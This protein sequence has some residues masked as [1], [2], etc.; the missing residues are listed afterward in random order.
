MPGPRLLFTF[1][2]CIWGGLLW[3]DTDSSL[4]RLQKRFDSHH[5]DPYAQIQDELDLSIA[6]NRLGDPK[7]SMS[8]LFTAL[9]IADSIQDKKEIALCQYKI[10]VL[11]DRQEDNENSLAWGKKGLETA[12]QANDSALVASCLHRIGL[13]Y[14]GQNKYDDALEVL[15]TSLDIRKKLGLKSGVAACMNAM[16]LIYTNKKEYDKAAFNITNAYTLWKEV[17]DEEGIAIATDNLAS[18]FLSAQEPEKAVHYGLISFQQAQKIHSFVFMKEAALTLSS[19]YEQLKDHKKAL[20]Y[21][22]RYSGIKDSLI[23]EESSQK[24]AYIQ[25][26]F[27]SDKQQA[28]IESL[29]K[30]KRQEG[31][32][33]NTLII[34]AI[35][36]AL[37]ALLALNRYRLKQKANQKL[38]EANE[39][40]RLSRDE[41]Q[42]Q[43]QEI[44]DSIRYAKRLQEALLPSYRHM[45][46]FL[47]GCF[48]LYKPKDIV[49][50]DF[51]WVEQWGGKTLIAAVD[52]T[53]HG[54]PGA[55]MSVLGYS[56][57]NRAVNELGLYKPALILNEMN[58][59]VSRLLRQNKEE[60][61]MKDGMDMA[62]LSIDMENKKLEFTG[63][64]N[65]CYLIR[66]GQLQI[67]RGDK[68]PVGAF[69]DDD[70]RLF[71]NQE[72]DLQ[73]GDVLYIFT[74]GYA[75]QFGGPKGKKFKHKQLQELLLSIHQKEPDEQNAQLNRTIMQWKGSLDQIDDILIVG[76]RI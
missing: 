68:F 72:H 12:K 57:L 21:Y 13:V 61:G 51:Y 49:S 28:Q 19:A 73:P 32:L 16:G 15:N 59:S 71:T 58:K 18:L 40:I 1:F 48:V 43:K 30:E 7:N 2:L 17:G 8:S 70:V 50:G 33:R 66:N 62:L 60:A 31:Q 65:P 74:D 29:Q 25:S 26:L 69:V 5:S 22:R 76:I 44:T 54:V 35:L 38:T 47:P 42:A 39:E 37:V 53:G 36:A 14:S 41:I 24:V 34:A 55:F 11:F 52:C 3:G 56:L 20:E 67:L 64:F 6:Y 46:R 23:N 63:A 45:K 4:V 75:D 27:E 10:A 9:G